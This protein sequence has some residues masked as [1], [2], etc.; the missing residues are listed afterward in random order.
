MTRDRFVQKL[1]S[2]W[3]WYRTG[4]HTEKLGIKA[5]RVLTVTKSEDRLRSLLSSVV[6]TTELS[7]ALAMF[8]FASEDGFEAEPG[9]RRIVDPIWNVASAPGDQRGLL[10]G[11]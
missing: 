11:A 3:H 8:W 2:Y 4:G 5:F 10:P 7:D 9:L 6:R 1:V